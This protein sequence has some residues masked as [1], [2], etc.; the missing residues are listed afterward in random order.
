MRPQEHLSSDFKELQQ[1][2]TDRKKRK[3]S[4]Q[5]E[6]KELQYEESQEAAVGEILKETI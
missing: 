2:A 1:R 6:K 3:E 4:T 5:K